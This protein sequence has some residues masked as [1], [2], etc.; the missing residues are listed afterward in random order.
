MQICL[1]LTN[2]SIILLP[3]SVEALSSRSIISCLILI[4]TADKRSVLTLL[5]DRKST[6]NR[7]REGVVEKGLF[8]MMNM[9]YF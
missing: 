1:E 5:L 4:M 2:E 3:Q 8:A 7:E 6:I 9:E